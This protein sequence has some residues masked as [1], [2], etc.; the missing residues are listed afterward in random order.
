MVTG[1]INNFGTVV[2]VAMVSE[3]VPLVLEWLTYNGV[4][5][6]GTAALARIASARLP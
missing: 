1:M 3:P 4:N 2:S 6:T 5:I